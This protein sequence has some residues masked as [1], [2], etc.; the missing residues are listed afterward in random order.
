MKLFS[1]LNLTLLIIIILINTILPQ[2]K[3]YLV[4]GSDT[5]IWDGM[6]VAKYHCY[7]NLDLF[8]AVN[9]NTAV[10]MSENFRNQIQDSYGSKLKMTWWM[11]GGN[12]FRYATNNNVPIG[13][14]MALHLMKKYYG[15]KIA[16]W[17]DELSLHYHTFFWSD[18]DGDGKYWWNQALNFTETKEDFDYT[19]AQ[20]LLEENTFPVSFR[21][22]WHYMDNE[23][24]N[25]LNELLP[26]SLHND[27]P[28][29]NKDLIEPTDND[30]DWSQASSEFVPFH[31]STENYQLPGDGKGWNVRSKY[32]GSTTQQLMDNIFLK[33][34]QG[35]DQLVCLWSHLPDQNFLNE[36]QQVNNL[37]H[38]SALNYPAVKFKYCTAVE[39]YQLWLQSSDSLKPELQLTEEISGSEIKFLIKS[40][41]PIF[42]RQPFVAIKD[43]Y[44]RY[45]IA[46]CENVSPNVWRTTNT[47]QLSDIAKV[48]VA[49][50]D[51]FGNLTTS[52]INYLPDDK[53]IDNNDSGFQEVY[54]VWNTSTTSSWNL[55]SKFATLVPDDSAKVR[56][57]LT[58]EYSGLYN[59]FIQFPEINNQIDTITFEV[60]QNNISTDKKVFYNL[61]NYNQ[62][63]Y[64]N[65]LN[66]TA[67]ENISIEMS[68]K[69]KTQSSKVFVADVIKLSA[70]VR[71]RQ[72]IPEK[73]FINIGDLSIEDSL[74]FDFQINNI[75][76]NALSI[77]DVYS[78]GG[79]IKTPLNYP[80]QIN[81]M[82]KVILPLIFIPND[83]G[84]VEDTIIIRSD[85]PIN[86]IYQIPIVVN[87]V[88]YFTIV[89]NDDP[90]VYKETGSWFNSVVQAFGNSSRYAFIQ[91]TS[92]GPTATFT[93]K[94]KKD[95][96]YDIYEILPKTVNS[97]NNALYKIG[98]ENSIIDSF[99]LNQNEGSGNWKNIGRYQLS[100]QL[101][102][103][104]RIIDS[105]ESTAG[106]VIRTDAFK[107][108][109][110]QELTDVSGKLTSS[111]PSEFKL[112]QNYPNPF[113]PSTIISWQVPVSSWQTLKV[114]DVL[115][116]EVATLVN[117]FKPAGSYS[118]EFSINNLLTGDGGAQLSSGIYFYQLKADNFVQT[119]KMVLTK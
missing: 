117:E 78:S 92:N 68:A 62:W 59:I 25:Y 104:I 41:E 45:Q 81:G 16:I 71:D 7:Y 14:T 56:W 35:T 107:F 34:S 84:L 106:D 60:F 32:M 54:G 11:I 17:G 75:G 1:T 22:G 10:V 77:S 98:S 3:V 112:G 118:I 73:L 12:M 79:N 36:I 63:L 110:I 65:N 58:P 95:G 93:L 100:A 9:S 90:T 44:E 108:S 39:A 115:G 15:D 18:Y 76:L 30:Y 105:G 28:A 50:T 40:N 8:T 51:T 5:A 26:Y 64:V 103:T 80:I 102:I 86:P 114:Y 66:F 89:D 111:I 53:F 94:L 91:G 55:D 31:P 61:Q 82:G 49:V 88:N 43:R 87:V 24:Q 6:D 113:N 23:W 67:G 4:L 97:T 83:L 74:Y 19:L 21:S 96:I 42:Q 70:Y 38:Q 52:F 101:P 13:N 29:K 27:W 46:E 2:G 72:L 109:L 119:K 85:D 116:R 47:S 20:F 69:N 57:N 37:A 99:Y 48:G 33:A